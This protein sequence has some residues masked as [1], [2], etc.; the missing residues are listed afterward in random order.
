M[1]TCV[2]GL[3]LAIS[4]LFTI[5]ADAAGGGGYPPMVGPSQPYPSY[6]QY[7]GAMW[8]TTPAPVVRYRKPPRRHTSAK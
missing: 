2:L 4:A 7:C 5:P 3:T 6:C 8:Q 1:K